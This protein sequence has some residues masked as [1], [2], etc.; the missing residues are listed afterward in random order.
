MKKLISSNIFGFSFYLLASFMLSNVSHAQSFSVS[1]DVKNYANDT[2]IIGSYFGEKQIV[3]DTLFATKS[4]KFDWKLK[5]KPAQGVYFIFMKPDNSFVQFMVNGDEKKFSMSCDAKDLNVINFKGSKENSLFYEYMAYLREKRI[6][7][8]TLRSRLNRAKTNDKEDSQAQTELEQLDKDVK[9]YQSEFVAN[10]PNSMTGMLVKANMEIN[11]PDFE[12]NE[13]AVKLQRYHYYK[14][15]YFDNVNMDHPGLIRTPYI[16]PKVD[17]F[18]NKVSSQLPDSII[19]SI[20]FVLQKLEKNPEA[21]R[22]YLS[23]ILNKYA[24]LKMVGHDAIYVHM[25]DNYYK[26]DKAPWVAKETIEKMSDQADEF[27]PI[28]IGKKMPDFTTY[29]EDGTPVRLY[30]IKATHTIVFFWDPTCGNC[31]KTTPFVVDFQ[32]KYKDHNLKILTVCKMAGEKLNTCWPYVKDKG[33]EDLINTG[34][35]YGRYN[36]SVRV[37]KVP[38]IFIL[39]EDK[40]IIIKDFSGEN[41]ENIYLQI[42]KEMEQPLEVK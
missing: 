37:T 17:Y 11:V 42:I 22:Y 40:K 18:L 19:V 13:D 23:D 14:T 31:K 7:A 1:F 6:L 26:K 39:D 16:H 30:D 34:D 8:D 10:H 25:V 27:R 41:L 9:K 24:E 32:K 4:G 5:D 12:G 29:K 36:Q 20:D 38:K 35:V 2:L 15:H 21:F 3:K 33:M 28:L